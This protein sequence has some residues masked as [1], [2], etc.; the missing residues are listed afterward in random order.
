MSAPSFP[1]LVVATVGDRKAR[2]YVRTLRLARIIAR[3][4]KVAGFSD[5]AVYDGLRRVS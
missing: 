1:F 2:T 3:Q 4:A 5:V